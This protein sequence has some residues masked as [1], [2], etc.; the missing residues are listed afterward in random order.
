LLWI[1]TP[2]WYVVKF[3]E[4]NSVEAVP[5]NWFKDYNNCFWP[6]YSKARTAE[7]IKQRE[8]PSKLWKLYKLKILS[9]KKNW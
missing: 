9:K 3:L 8:T 2:G 1:L 4:E 6:Q 7:A 5:C